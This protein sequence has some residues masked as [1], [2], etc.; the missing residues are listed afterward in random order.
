MESRWDAAAAGAA[1]S[2]GPAVSA[3]LARARCAPWEAGLPS[4]RHMSRLLGAQ[5]GLLML[6]KSRKEGSADRL[7]QYLI[8]GC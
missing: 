8:Q 2:A 4:L 1:A 7:S 3:E 5:D 6:V